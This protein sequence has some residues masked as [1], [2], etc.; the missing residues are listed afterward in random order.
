MKSGDLYK[1]RALGTLHLS[2][3]PICLFCLYYI[4]PA[5]IDDGILYSIEA[6]VLS[7]V[8]IVG[9]SMLT[10]GIGILM[11]KKWALTY[12]SISGI[13]LLLF[14]P[15]G[16]ILG[17]WTLA[18]H[19]KFLARGQRNDHGNK[20]LGSALGRYGLIRFI[21][22]LFLPIT[23]IF[24]ISSFAWDE[25]AKIVDLNR[26]AKVF[27]DN[28]EMYYF[29]YIGNQTFDGRDRPVYQYQAYGK[30]LD[31]IS[32]SKINLPDDGRVRL[33]KDP[34]ARNKKNLSQIKQREVAIPLHG[35][36][37]IETLYESMRGHVIEKDIKK[38]S[39]LTAAA[40]F[41]IIIAFI[42]QRIIFRQAGITS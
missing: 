40:F 8:T 26:S 15:I 42:L 9:I 19:S 2:I 33:G 27:R 4:W 5:V 16:T 36:D 7:Y 21:R 41:S 39:I 38:A 32:Y 20:N 17:I 10:G 34:L 31:F 11:R 3:G 18:I 13:L 30:T 37:T 12:M 24:V 1:I 28:S 23:V 14:I 6:I 22:Y 25:W 29:T 35:E